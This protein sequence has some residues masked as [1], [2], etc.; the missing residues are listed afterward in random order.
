MP[1]VLRSHYAGHGNF[2]FLLCRR[3]CAAPTRDIAKRVVGLAATI[4]IKKIKQFAFHH[5]SDFLV[6]VRR[7]FRNFPSSHEF[8]SIRDYIRNSSSFRAPPAP[9]FSKAHAKKYLMKSWTSN[10]YVISLGIGNRLG[11]WI[12]E[13]WCERTDERVAQRAQRRKTKKYYQ[14]V[15]ISIWS[16][17]LELLFP[18]DFSFVF[19]WN[20]YLWSLICI[21]NGFIKFDV[22]LLVFEARDVRDASDSSE[23]GRPKV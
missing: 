20:V 19:C 9:P 16:L 7:A 22:H 11:L 8:L 17:N 1:L 15:S 18:R 6:L 13:Q 5:E 21:H 12:T 23:L 2:S 10:K 3:R 14:N 4:K